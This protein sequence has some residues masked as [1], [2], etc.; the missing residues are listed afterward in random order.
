MGEWAIV[1]YSAALAEEV[2]QHLKQS[3]R[4]IVAV[5]NDVRRASGSWHIAL[6]VF[7]SCVRDA[8]T[9]RGPSVLDVLISYQSKLIRFGRFT[10]AQWNVLPGLTS[11][12]CGVFKRHVFSTTA[13]RLRLC[14]VLGVT[15]TGAPR[16]VRTI[17]TQ[18]RGRFRNPEWTK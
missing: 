6:K 1:K 3:I 13:R 17:I 8:P 16:T 18:S 4:R 11:A 10:G 2:G 9:S 14:L 7:S 12:A 15:F 5:R